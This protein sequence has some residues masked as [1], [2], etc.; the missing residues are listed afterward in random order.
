MDPPLSTIAPGHG[1]L[2]VDP[3][4][5]LEG[6]IEHR[7]R[8]GGGRRRRTG[9]RRDAPRWTSCLPTVYADVDE[10]PCSRWPGTRCG[11]ICASSTP[12]A[13]PATEDPADIEAP[14]E[15]AR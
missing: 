8:S 11:R 12:T 10:E 9:R 13:A 6:I 7:L 15:A 3:A 1:S 14:W 2:I 5:A 4:A